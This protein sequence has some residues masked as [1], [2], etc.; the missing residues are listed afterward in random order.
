MRI[1]IAAGT[2][3]PSDKSIL[4]EICKS[5]LNSK[6]ENFNSVSALF[7]PNGRFDNFKDMYIQA[8]AHLLNIPES[9]SF[10]FISENKMKRGKPVS[11]SNEDWF[12]S[13]GK[14][15]YD[16]DLGE[17]IKKHSSFAE[18][19]I[20][21]HLF[22]YSIETQLPFIQSIA[23][24]PKMVAISI[25]TSNESIV[26]DLVNS[27]QTSANTLNKNIVLIATCQMLR[28]R[29]SQE[30]ES[31]TREVIDIINSYD[32][33]SKKNEDSLFNYFL[34]QEC[35]VNP[36][37]FLVPL[38]YSIKNNFRPRI[39]SQKAIKTGVKEEIEVYL[40]IAYVK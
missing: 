21:A 23:N 26:K 11:I 13:L 39:L 14:V 35:M 1:P 40:S 2:F 18:F 7:V 9:T 28:C 32:M 34:N 16:K 25:S 5:M 17:Q 33:Y 27:I 3:Y 6:V 20:S 22:E 29:S 38:M 4:K 24:S 19:D 30:A 37:V 10:I 12:T 8:Y 15:A 31:K 36:T